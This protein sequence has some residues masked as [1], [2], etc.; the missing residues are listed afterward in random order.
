M[1]ARAGDIIAATQMRMWFTDIA[2]EAQDSVEYGSCRE[3]AASMCAGHSGAVGHP[4]IS[5]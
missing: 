2:S 5:V 1:T 3:S 4:T